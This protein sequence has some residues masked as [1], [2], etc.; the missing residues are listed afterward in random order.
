MKVTKHRDGTVS[1]T[2]LSVHDVQNLG[3]AASCAAAS[4]ARSLNAGSTGSNQAWDIS[5]MGL[6]ERLRSRLEVASNSS[7]SGPGAH[8]LPRGASMEVQSS[9]W[10]GAQAYGWLN[11]NMIKVAPRDES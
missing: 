1:L 11:S 9:D 2:G 3:Y 5:Q 8:Y 6:F 4:Y 10:S 7:L